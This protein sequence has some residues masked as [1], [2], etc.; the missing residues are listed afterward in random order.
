MRKSRGKKE[1]NIKEVLGEGV[2]I[3][4]SR[5]SI[6]KK[7]REFFITLVTSLT[8]LDDRTFN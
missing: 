1:F 2:K 3:K 5:K 4:E 6:L 8:D 7:D